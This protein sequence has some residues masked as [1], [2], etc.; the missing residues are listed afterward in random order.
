MT[1][2]KDPTMGLARADRRAAR[3]RRKRF[4]GQLGTSKF[5]TEPYGNRRARNRRRNAAARV[6][7]RVNR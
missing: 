2:G 1:G 4:E 5:T 6:A 7:R 3:Y